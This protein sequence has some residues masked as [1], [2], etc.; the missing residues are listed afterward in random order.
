M[1]LRLV[2]VLAAGLL[3]STGAIAAGDAAKGT[4]FATT[5]CA[6]CHGVDG[7][8]MPAVE[9]QPVNPRLAGQPAEYVAK[10]L[11]DFKGG[12]RV[13]PVMTGMASILTPEDMANLGAY[14]AQQK[15]A[16]GA[17]KENGPGSMGEKIYKGGIAGAGVPACTSCHGPDGAGIPAQFPRVGGQ[18]VEYT[19]VQLKAFRSGERANDA[20][21]MMRTI[22]GKMSDQELAAVADYIQGL[23]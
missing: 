3:G 20:A 7:N 17:A 8:G 23:H 1:D 11:A 19:I 12:T 13:N 14:F 4:T 10:Q 9:G 16:S 15:A 2:L 21:S 18:H 22:V 5:V 6:A